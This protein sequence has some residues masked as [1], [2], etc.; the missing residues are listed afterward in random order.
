MT[1]KAPLRT[2]AAYASGALVISLMVWPSLAANAATTSADPTP[3]EDR[4]ADGA[5]IFGRA[6][7]LHISDRDALAW[8]RISNGDPTDEV[9][10]DRSYDN[11][12]T[13]ADSRLG[14]SRIPDGE[15]SVQTP[16][17]AINDESTGRRG[18]VRA[19][20]K[21]GNR[22]DIVCTAWIGVEKPKTKGSP[23][24]RA[25]AALVKLYDQETGLWKTT[26]WWNSA[27]AL[28]AVIDYMLITG[29]RSYEWIIANTYDKNIDAQGGNF[30]NDYIDDTG[31]WALAWI[32]AYDLTGDQRYLETAKF[33]ADYMWSS[34]DDVCG[35]GL[36]WNIN[37]RYKNAVT[38]ELFIK[39]AASL[40]NRIPGD[41]I[42]LDRAL[43]I[44]QWFQNSG[45]INS[46]NLI[47]DGLD[48]TTCQN[49]GGTTWSYNQGIIL[50]ALTELA[51][52]TG[53]AGYL[54]QARTLADASSTSA[55][56]NPGGV[57]REPCEHD[58]C[59]ADG[60]TFKGV[61]VRNLGELNAA[62]P[63]HPYQPYLQRQAHVSYVKD[64]NRFDQ[65]GL[66][67]AG[68]IA[69]LGAATQQSGAEAQT[70]PLRKR[71][72]VP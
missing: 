54:A 20:G 52:A 14:Y 24:K 6:I 42:Y 59:G 21:A 72:P 68:P 7:E 62:L 8:A 66:H 2:I 65:Y 53:D 55:F 4:L 22:D 34:R 28:T 17:I 12:E 5:T 61:Y 51:A 40:H 16:P 47:N 36:V 46:E 60:P 25:V 49:N 30:T 18:V 57:L 44:W 3:T 33:D 69:F 39:V 9:W 67:W 48:G 58:G 19:C 71:S 64:R 1:T 10:L 70:A 35:G 11:G 31:W 37:Q 38:N 45:M 13:V 32:R 23:S 15:R 29:D 50:G 43:E 56:L 41:A 63:N 26:G 27:N